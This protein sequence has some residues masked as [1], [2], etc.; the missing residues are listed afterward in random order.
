[1]ATVHW[2][3]FGNQAQL[4]TTPNDPATQTEANGAIGHHAV[5][6]DQIKAVEI[7]GGTRNITVD[8]QRT[9]A[10]A[11]TYNASNTS[12]MTYAS[13][14]SGETVT[15]QITGFLSVR[16][17]LTIPLAD[18]GTKTE[19][20]TGVLIQMRNGDM[21]FRPAKDTVNDWDHIDALR[22]VTI[23]SA[24]PLN[25]NTYVAI[26]SFNISIHDV[27]IVPCFTAGTLILT[28]QGQCRVED[29]QPGDLVWTRDHGL[30]PLRWR[31]RRTLDS[32]ELATL[33][34]LRPIRIMAGALGAG[35]PA[36]DLTVSPQHRVL[37][38]SSIAQRMFGTDE[39]LV[40]AKQLLELPGINIDAEATQVTYLHLLFDQHEV[41]LSNGAETESLYPGPQA[42]TG[43]GAAAEEIFALFPEL[44]DSLD[45]FPAARPF[46]SGRKAQRMAMRHVMNAQPLI[47]WL[48]DS[49]PE[50]VQQLDTQP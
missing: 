13:P 21:F 30:Q 47:S 10:F 22:A 41:I 17:E 15:S 25:A 34:R 40:A 1:M 11:T 45:D 14:T 42:I 27:E 43:L 18:G 3:W 37:V 23:V 12:N 16:Y 35:Q 19:E 38:R 26:I 8:G 50:P 39:I 20:Q 9:Q 6:P 44:R 32:I 48:P 46:A 7:T 2:I 28:D 5:G 24:E 33:S 4:N 36:Q 29:L 49:S 31:G